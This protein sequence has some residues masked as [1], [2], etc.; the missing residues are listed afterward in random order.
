MMWQMYAAALRSI[1]REEAIENVEWI[2]L[3][4]IILVMLVAV[5]SMLEVGGQSIGGLIVS[6][7]MEWIKIWFPS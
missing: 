6:Q 1:K 2:A 7:I 3:A 5:G 4:A